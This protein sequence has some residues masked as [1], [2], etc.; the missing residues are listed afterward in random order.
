MKQFLNWWRGFWTS[1]E[2]ALLRAE[3]ERLIETNLALEQE[4]VALRKD[5]R[6]LVNAQ[7]K[8]AGIVSLPE[9]ADEKPEPI[10]RIRKL[11][12]HQRQRVHSMRTD[13][14]R[15]MEEKHGA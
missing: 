15:V 13:P 12:L 3:N 9:L 4:I 10:N 8:Q 14:Q 1:K 7:L 5:N 11:S 2:T 6:A